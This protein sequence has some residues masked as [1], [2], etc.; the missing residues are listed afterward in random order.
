M[1]I[2]MGGTI[3]P[4]T[5]L[6]YWLSR[7]LPAGTWWGVG[8]TIMVALASPMWGFGVGLAHEVVT[9]G[10]APRSLEVARAMAMGL[11][12][13]ILSPLAVLFGRRRR[14]S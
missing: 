5:V 7:R 1:G 10:G 11:W 9:N 4:M 6:A 12:M 14:F 8:V 2:V 13:L 3:V